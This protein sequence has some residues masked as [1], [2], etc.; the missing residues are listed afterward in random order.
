MPGTIDEQSHLR[1]QHVRVSD[2]LDDKLQ[3]SAD[4]DNIDALIDAVNEQH[5]L[6]KKQ[7][8]ITQGCPT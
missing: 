5:D 7:V 6:L 8:S 2:Y 4:F 3:T 1:D